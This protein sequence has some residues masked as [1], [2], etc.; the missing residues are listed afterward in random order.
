MHDNPAKFIDKGSFPMMLKKAAKY[1]QGANQS[2][3]APVEFHEQPVPESSDSKD[4]PVYGMKMIN[5]QRL[6]IQ[7]HFQMEIS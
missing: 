6:P 5:S 4:L 3:Y 2:M 1:L 7:P